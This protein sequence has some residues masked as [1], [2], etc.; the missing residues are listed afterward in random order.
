MARPRKR[1]LKD[2]KN[3]LD[4]LQAEYEQRAREESLE[5]V[6]ASREFKSVAKKLGVLGLST[7]QIGELFEHVP[8]RT[9]KASR[10]KKPRRKVKPKYRSPEDPNITWTGRGNKPLWVKAALEGGMEMEDLLIEEEASE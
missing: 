7:R 1:T 4:K 3:D 5:D 2:I 8:T 6:L 9:V 10:V